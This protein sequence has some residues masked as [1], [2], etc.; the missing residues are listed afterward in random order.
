MYEDKPKEEDALAASPVEVIYPSP[1][2]GVSAE[3]APK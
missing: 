1:V 2:Y 3:E